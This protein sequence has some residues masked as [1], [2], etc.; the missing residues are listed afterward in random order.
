VES[1]NKPVLRVRLPGTVSYRTA[2]DAMRRF[3]DTRE[4]GA[5][6][7]IWFL[8][9]PPVY[10]LGLNNKTSPPPTGD[11]EVVQ[12]DR[13]GQITY[14]GPGQLI[15]Y[16]MLD[17]QRLGIGIRRLVELLE[18]SVIALLAAND[19]AGQRKPGAPGVYVENRKISALG[20]RV[21]KRGSYHGLA[22]N[23]DMDLEPFSRIDPCGYRGM[24]VTDLKRL[25]ISMKRTA[26][27]QFLLRYFC[28]QLGYTLSPGPDTTELP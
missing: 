20:L 22:L 8:E 6:D 25:G 24:E 10:T 21:R 17:L 4:Q 14:H 19:I 7:E 27:E 9:H 11:I 13:G 18:D 26:I 12:S 5:D 1:T 3:N 15:V 2:W 28:D 16:T 23:M